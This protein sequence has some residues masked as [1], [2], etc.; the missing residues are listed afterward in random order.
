MGW[1]NL[2]LTL[3]CYERVIV[4]KGEV[5]LVDGIKVVDVLGGVM[6]KTIDAIPLVEDM[7]SIS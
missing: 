6:P 2:A 4:G 1:V 7:G 3:R 5:E